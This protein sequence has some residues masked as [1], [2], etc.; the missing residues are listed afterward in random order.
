[1]RCDHLGAGWSRSNG[2]SQASGRAGGGG[3]G[4][5]DGGGDGDDDEVDDIGA[6]DDVD[7]D[8]V[9]VEVDEDVDVQAT[10]AISAMGRVRVMPAGSEHRVA[11]SARPCAILTFVIGSRSEAFARVA[12]LFGR[13]A[14]VFADREAILERHALTE[15]SYRALERRTIEALLSASP[16]ELAHFARAFAEERAEL[17]GMSLKDVKTLNLSSEASSIAGRVPVPT[18][19]APPP[20]APASS[21]RP[22]SLA[23]GRTDARTVPQAA[24]NP[25]SIDDL[26][27]TLH[28]PSNMNAQRRPR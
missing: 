10:R 15:D 11:E 25:E 7:E 19:A 27:E 28:V 2:T 21:P 8:E 3:D 13:L 17:L 26:M 1:M 12:H 23:A 20:S 14:H 16:A 9:E 22:P 18:G 24:Y 4:S 6:E 5:E